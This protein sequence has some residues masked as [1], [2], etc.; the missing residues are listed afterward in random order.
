MRVHM[1]FFISAAIR[2][3]KPAPFFLHTSPDFF[4]SKQSANTRLILHGARV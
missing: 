2:P 4:E 1:L 3:D